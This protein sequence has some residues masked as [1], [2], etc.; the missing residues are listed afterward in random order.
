MRC[1]KK[2][3]II[4][5]S[6]RAVEDWG[7]ILGDNVAAGVILDRFL[8]HTEIIKLDGRSYCLADRREQLKILSKIPSA[9]SVQNVVDND[10]TIQWREVFANS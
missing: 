9:M 2:G 1:Y 4:V 8:H 6:N 7:T 3:A 5:T 10:V